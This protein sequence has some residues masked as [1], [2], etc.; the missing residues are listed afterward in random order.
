VDTVRA[1]I[2]SALQGQV[3][4]RAAVVDVHVVDVWPGE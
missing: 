2:G 3:G 4:V 1:R